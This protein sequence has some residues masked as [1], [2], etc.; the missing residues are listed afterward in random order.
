MM[1]KSRGGRK[2][3]A[4]VLFAA[5]MLVLSSTV[6]SGCFGGSP[7]PEA[8]S[9]NV[10]S[11]VKTVKAEPV[12]KQKVAETEERTG[13]AR[14]SAQVELKSKYKGSI[15]EVFKNRGDTVQ[16][17]D[18]VLT[19]ESEEVNQMLQKAAAALQDA[20]DALNRA[21]SKALKDR[22]I[23]RAEFDYSLSKQKQKVE[24]AE[25][26][27]NRLRN[28]YDVR[29][30]TKAKLEQ[31]EREWKDAQAELEQ[32][33]RKQS[34]L[35]Q[36]SFDELEKSVREALLAQE[37]AEQAASAL[38]IKAPISGVLTGAQTIQAGLPLEAND[39][40]GTIQKL[41][42]IYIKSGFAEKDAKLVRGKAELEYR[43]SATEAY[44]PAPVIFL[45]DIIDTELK[46]Y[47]IVMQ[48]A[49]PDNGLKPGTKVQLR[50]TKEEELI[51]PAVPTYSIIKDGDDAFVFVLNG[52]TVE[53]R[54]IQPG[55]LLEPYQEVLSGVKEGEL[56][57]TS[58]QNL[59]SDRE[60]VKLP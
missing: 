29:L 55:R 17:G 23:S 24:D 16:A 8:D 42:P 38:Q 19:L 18:T 46:L 59:L 28:D 14:A 50:L 36:V 41:D 43:L 6:L 13:E 35:E 20:Q 27:Y 11:A 44:K 5:G 7:S 32:L 1:R 51:A 37:Q 31:A 10:E 40:I 22:E 4:A 52:D 9:G 49:N 54:K 56:V 57:V 53:K 47:E 60:K 3:A 30:T 45:S 33:Q 39:A 12:A 26:A 48:I 2:S 58:G 21:K 15:K 25:K 34:A